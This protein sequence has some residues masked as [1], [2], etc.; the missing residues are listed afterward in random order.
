M[1]DLDGKTTLFPIKSIQFD[2][3]MLQKIVLLSNPVKRNQMDLQIN[4]PGSYQLSIYNMRGQILLERNINNVEAG[5]RHTL[6]LPDIAAG[7]YVLRVTNGRHQ[8]TS[9]FMVE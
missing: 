8:H 1:V 3:G 6:M 7:I 5:K 2:E 9:M 4:V